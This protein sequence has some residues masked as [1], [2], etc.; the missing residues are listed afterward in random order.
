MVWG[1]G[2]ACFSRVRV[3]GLNMRDV[4]GVIHCSLC[5]QGRPPIL[6]A[7]CELDGYQLCDSHAQ[8]VRDHPGVDFWKLLKGAQNAT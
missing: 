1:M 2:V 7:T 6:P 5:L 8:T 4:G 3:G